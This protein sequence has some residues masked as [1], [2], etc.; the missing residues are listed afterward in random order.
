MSEAWTITLAVLV[1]I[2]VVALF[3]QIGLY[4][5][6]FSLA[7]RMQARVEKSTPGIRGL[8]TLAR[9]IREENWSNVRGAA[10][11]AAGIAGSVRHDAELVGEFGGEVARG[12]RSTREQASM[13]A[14]DARYRAHVTASLVSRGVKAP[15][16]SVVRGIRRARDLFEHRAA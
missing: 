3:V 6:M 13:V 10:T 2:T 11:K 15:F 12:F 7:R 1:G 9:Q 8:M 14:D 5:A 4:L 16:L